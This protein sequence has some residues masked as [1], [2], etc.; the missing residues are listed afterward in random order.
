MIRRVQNAVICILVLCFIVF[1]GGCATSRIPA[2]MQDCEIK[3][4]VEQWDS[5]AD[6]KNASLE[7]EDRRY[8]REQERLL[9]ESCVRPYWWDARFEKC[10]TMSEWL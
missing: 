7:R 2:L 4:Y 6:C 5:V 8:K 10:R 3:R 9:H 1:C